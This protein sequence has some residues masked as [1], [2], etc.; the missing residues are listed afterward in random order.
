MMACQSARLALHEVAP[1]AC[2]GDTESGGIR[3]R[4]A[5]PKATAAPL[6]RVGFVLVDS[7]NITNLA[8]NQS[9]DSLKIAGSSTKLVQQD[10]R[11]GQPPPWSFVEAL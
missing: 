6:K 3:F 8:G 5:E 7:L 2:R 10:T 1:T 9:L 11:V 4:Q